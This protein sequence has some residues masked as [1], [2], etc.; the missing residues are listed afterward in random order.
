VYVWST[1]I[2][3]AIVTEDKQ[4]AAVSRAKTLVSIIDK[5]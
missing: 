2:L 5:K 4:L 3:N 1:M